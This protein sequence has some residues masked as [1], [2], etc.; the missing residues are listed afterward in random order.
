MKM[1]ILLIK[2]LEICMAVHDVPPVTMQYL[3]L[4]YSLYSPHSDIDIS[5]KFMI[6]AHFISIFQLGFYMHL[7]H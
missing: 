6:I 4:L 5:I 1:L 2:C 7:E 3:K